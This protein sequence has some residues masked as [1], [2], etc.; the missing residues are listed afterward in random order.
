MKKTIL[1]LSLSLAMTSLQAGKYTDYCYNQGLHKQEVYSCLDKLNKKADK[2]VQDALNR[3]Q[4]ASLDLSGGEKKS[5]QYITSKQINKLMYSHES[6][7]NEQCKL[8]G[9][10]ILGTSFGQESSDCMIYQKLK[11]VD[12]INYMIKSHY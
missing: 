10:S 8:L 9:A 3:L 7:N 2:K 6:Y 11:F 5:S 4:K 1:V 12:D